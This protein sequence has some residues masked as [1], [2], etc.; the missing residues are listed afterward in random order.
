MFERECYYSA[1]Y[2]NYVNSD[3]DKICTLSRSATAEWR[4]W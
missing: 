2:A 1:N 4:L 3:S